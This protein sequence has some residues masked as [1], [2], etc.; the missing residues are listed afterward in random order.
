MLIEKNT[1][2]KIKFKNPSISAYVT[3]IKSL[4]WS[5]NFYTSQM[6]DSDG[7][8][9]YFTHFNPLYLRIWWSWISA[10]VE[11]SPDR[12]TQVNTKLTSSCHDFSP[13]AMWIVRLVHSFTS[14]PNLSW[15]FTHLSS[16]NPLWLH[17]LIIYQLEHYPSNKS[18][19]HLSLSHFTVKLFYLKCHPLSSSADVCLE[20]TI[21]KTNRI[22]S[23]NAY[24]WAPRLEILHHNLGV[25]LS[26]LHAFIS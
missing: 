14:W 25:E 22:T 13:R 7:T 15:S 2:T 26:N 20:T 17:R 23:L 12:P 3:V 9:L 24:S 5:L 1:Q 11:G 16:P 6:Q 10:G 4:P 19:L 8:V 21:I 18:S